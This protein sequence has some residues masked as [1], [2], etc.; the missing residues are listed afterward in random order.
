[1]NGAVDALSP[2]D[3]W[4]GVDILMYYQNVKSVLTTK[5]KKTRVTQLDG[6]LSSHLCIQNSNTGLYPTGVDIYL[7]IE[8]LTIGADIISMDW[9]SYHESG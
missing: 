8:F 7:K 1:M 4:S 6:N 2:T 5:E 9:I 3:P